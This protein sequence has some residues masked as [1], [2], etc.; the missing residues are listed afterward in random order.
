MAA[1][2]GGGGAWIVP[3]NKSQ[4]G[5]VVCMCLTGDGGRKRW[6]GGGGGW[7]RDQGPGR[8][9][10]QRRGKAPRPSKHTLFA[11]CQCE[12]ENYTTYLPR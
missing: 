3:M 2:L 8:G 9:S 12:R 10:R 11:A 6:V 7:T 4:P 5:L 1:R